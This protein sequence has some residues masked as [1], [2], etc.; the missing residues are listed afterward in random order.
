M[1]VRARGAAVWRQG[2]WMGL[3]DALEQYQP[4]ADVVDPRTWARVRDVALEV[5]SRF[6][7]ATSTALNRM[8]AL[9][10]YLAWAYEQDLPLVPEVLW[11]EDRIEAFTATLSTPSVSTYRSFLRKI[12]RANADRRTVWTPTPESFGRA[13]SRTLYTDEEVGRFLRVVDQQATD[14]RRFV[15]GSVLHLC[16][17]FGLRSAELR[18]LMT[19]SITQEDGLVLYR[20]AGRV[21]P[22]RARY[23]EGIVRLVD[24]VTDERYFGDHLGSGPPFEKVLDRIE[25]P[26]Y[27]PRLQVRILRNTWL[28]DVMSEGNLTLREVQA[29]AGLR[30]GSG[31]DAVAPHLP[32]RQ[33][34]YLRRAAGVD[35]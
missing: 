17:G 28:V 27:L 6:D 33:D 29:V 34:T 16:L 25:I 3:R 23:A 10:Q 14:R 24:G 2:H 12:A 13:D 11:T 26:R 31:F 20:G 8:P 15:L 22:A 32:V 5:A 30:S 35:H 18:G 19:R 1:T 9:A 7:G 21:V 4:R